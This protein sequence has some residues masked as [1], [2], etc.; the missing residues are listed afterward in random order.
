M[1]ATAV[2]AKPALR[3]PD[4]AL[5]VSQNP[6]D[7][8]DR[9]VKGIHLWHAQH[10]K[11]TRC[12][13][14]HTAPTPTLKELETE[15][16]VLTRE[17]GRVA[18]SGATTLD[19]TNRLFLLLQKTLYKASQDLGE[20]RGQLFVQLTGSNLSQEK[21]WE[22]FHA[23]K[24]AVEE[25]G[26]KIVGPQKVNKL[27]EFQTQMTLLFAP[28]DLLTPDL[29][30]ALFLL[31]DK[32]ECSIQREIEKNWH[33]LSQAIIGFQV[34][35]KGKSLENQRQMLKQHLCALPFSIQQRIEVK[36]REVL[37]K[38]A[39]EPLDLANAMVDD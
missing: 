7:G 37:K 28:A 12:L 5:V 15:L 4:T 36:L 11:Y 23:F 21:A 13:V 35:P 27:V 39:G 22:Q 19:R 31:L 2:T 3:A 17:I 1:S 29:M 14:S 34:D 25:I 20:M 10:A 32:M 16:T 9:I 24:K 38:T 26:G 8:L 6:F 18:T 33:D 30:D